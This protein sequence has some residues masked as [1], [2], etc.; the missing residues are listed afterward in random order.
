MRRLRLSP[1]STRSTV[2]H[3]F[4]RV[5][6]HVE[7]ERRSGSRVVGRRRVGVMAVGIAA[8]LLLLCMQSWRRE[9]AEVSAG[10]GV[11]GNGLEGRVSR[12]YGWRD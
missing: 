10:N 3:I 1:A 7:V 9:W 12:G 5:D 6:I 11:L 4:Q 8:I 2:R